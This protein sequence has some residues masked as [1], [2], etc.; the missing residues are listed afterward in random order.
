MK[1]N[2]FPFAFIFLTHLLIAQSQ[3]ELVDLELSNPNDETV[4]I[5]KI[6]PSEVSQKFY[7]YDSLNMFYAGGWSLGQSFGIGSSPTGDTL[8]IG[9]GA[10]VIIMDVTDPFNPVKL[11]EI[12]ARALIDGMFYDP[13]KNILLLAAYFSGLEIWDLTD[14][15]NPSK[16]SRASVT[17]LPRSGIFSNCSEADHCFTVTVADGMRVFDISDPV[18]PYEVANQSLPGLIWNSAVVGNYIFC[19]AGN[20][21][22]RIYDVSAS[23]SITQFGTISGV[24]NALAV[25]ETYAYTLNS[26]FG[27]RIYDW[28][29]QPTVMTGE[30]EISGYP[31]RNITFGDHTY[32]ANSTTN[33]GGGMNVIEISDPDIP[34]H[35]SDYPGF[36]TYITGNNNAVYTTGSPDGCLIFDI[37]DPE[38]PALAS[39]FEIPSSVNDIAV[40]GNYAFTGSNGFRVFDISDKSH[41]TQVG[42]EPTDG[43]LVKTTGNYAVYCPKSMGSSNPVNIM[44]ISDKENPAKVGTYMAPVMTYDLDLKGHYAFVACWW[45]GFRVIDF[46][47]PNSPTLA[48]HEMGWVNGAIPGEE[49]CYVQALDIEGDYLYLVD[50]KPFEDD[51]TKGVYIF[52]ISDPEN[53]IMIK[54][55]P[56]YQGKGYDIEVS[57]GIAYIADS[58]AGL[59]LV[60]VSDPFSP[61]Q[62]AYLPL[63]DVA[64]AVDVFGSYAFVANY[65]NGGVQVINISNPVSPIIEG[66]YKR[67]GCFALNVTYAAGHVFVA[68]GPAGIQIYNF[69]LL[70]GS[71]SNTKNIIECEVYP[72]PALEKFNI[73]LMDTENNPVK[74]ELF[75]LNGRKIAE[76]DYPVNQITYS[77]DASHLQAGVYII[78]VKTNNRETLKKVILQ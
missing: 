19:A 53:P 23:P 9:S 10:G 44:D 69:D 29:Q 35:I 57:N 5:E 3:F 22:A 21:G 18:N 59:T 7:E 74:I 17:G 40:Q 26:S 27:L 48:A 25:D 11:S 20:S 45:D 70:S 64:W 51:D 33:P 67:S 34:E 4:K 58:E 12:H 62:I 42:Y 56:E 31:Y 46:S 6:L 37:S 14:I 65:I 13:N 71:G 52:D 41:P 72:N 2:L 60:D 24:V 75:D 54:R 43:A 73:R 61:Q 49:W 30:L 78:K 16:I 15:Q 76:R 36:Q 55:L 32:I 28:V 8:F 50:Y 1:N 38:N 68:D 77:I 39:S 66:Y 47:N 63:V